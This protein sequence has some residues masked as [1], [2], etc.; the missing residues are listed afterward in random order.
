MTF[1]DVKSCAIYDGHKEH[2]VF[3]GMVKPFI[4][5][6]VTVVDMWQNNFPEFTLY[7]HTMM[8]KPGN[9]DPNPGGFV[10]K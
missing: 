6:A 9:A 10:G 5:E 3:K 8:S 2:Q 1:T 4:R 7:G